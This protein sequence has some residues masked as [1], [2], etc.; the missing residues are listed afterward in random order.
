LRTSW[1]FGKRPG[2]TGSGPVST[3][4]VLLVP[5][6]SD[7]LGL[8]GFVHDATV[9][10]VMGVLCFALLVDRKKG[11]TL[12]EAKHLKQVPWGILLLFGGGFAVAAG[13]EA[14]GLTAYLAERLK[15]LHWL[16]TPLV[17]AATALLMTFL[18]ELT[19]NTATTAMVLPILAATARVLQVNPL[20]LM[21]LATMA[22]SCAFMLPIA[23]PP[24]AIVFATGRITLPQMAR[25]GFYL[26]F[27]MTAVITFYVYAVVVPLFGID[28]SA[29]PAWLMNP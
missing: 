9:A 18:T 10:M 25:T 2:S 15:G 13:F 11:I 6:W 22:A 12:L 7:L 28:P 4:A 27:I 20:L 5:G 19:S 23:T 14:S 24:N 8:Q 21:V 17:V 1:P 16:A 26:N 29:P 3:P